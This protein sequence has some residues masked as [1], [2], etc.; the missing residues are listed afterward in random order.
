MLARPF[1]EFLAIFIIAFSILLMFFFPNGPLRSRRRQPNSVQCCH[2]SRPLLTWYRAG[3][4]GL[5]HIQT[6]RRIPLIT[7]RHSFCEGLGFA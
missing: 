5:R 2:V 4:N 7:L 3:F 6:Q 1:I